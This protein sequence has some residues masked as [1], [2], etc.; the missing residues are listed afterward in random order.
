MVSKSY[1]RKRIPVLFCFLSMFIF[2]VIAV[3]S[4]YMYFSNQVILKEDV[5]DSS[6]P[7]DP[8]PTKSELSLIMVGDSLIHSAVYGD[9]K[10]DDGYDFSPCFDNV[11]DYIK[12]YDLAFYNQESILGGEE[13]GL[14][15]YPRFNSP[16]AVGDAFREMG[17]NLVSLA[18]NHT[19]DR[20]E[21]AIINSRKYWNQ[22]PDIIVSGSN[23]SYEEQNDIKILEMNG[24][25]YTML[26]YTDLTNGLSTNGKEYLVNHYSEER[27]KKDIESVHDQVDLLMVSMHFGEEYKEQPTAKQKK[28]AEYL[29]SLGVDIVIGHH[30][31]VVE[32]IEFIGNTMVIYSLGNFISA[33]RGVER[34]TGLMASVKVV[35]EIVDEKTVVSL[36]NPSAELVYT[37]S[38][39][40]KQ[41][42]RHNFKLYRY[43]D[44]TDAI[45]GNYLAYQERFLGIVNLEK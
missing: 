17:F 19:L 44:L 31:H 32:P 28:I 38:N 10:T 34:L 39:Y 27:V 42:Y 16:Y 29:S 26:A 14:S 45:L 21:A 5:V 41:G 15:T 36:E 8:I 35:K 30:P 11:R 9:A 18:N 25:R 23:T 20:G 3:M 43:Q 40:D 7:E 6:I 4:I 1:K 24:I 13:L 22:F 37:S 12:S 2:E 33:Q